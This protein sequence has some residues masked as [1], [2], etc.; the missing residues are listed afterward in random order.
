MFAETPVPW[1]RR[2]SSKMKRTLANAARAV[3]FKGLNPVSSIR[4][5]MSSWTRVNVP[6]NP[7]TA[8][9]R[10]GALRRSVSRRRF[11]RAKWER[12]LVAK[13]LSKPSG[14]VRR[15][16]VRVAALICLEGLHRTLL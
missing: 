9:T 12:W 6:G 7:E 13:M 4:L 14:V 11:V 5:S 1:V 3:A 15:S 2:A 16:R 10:E 8:I